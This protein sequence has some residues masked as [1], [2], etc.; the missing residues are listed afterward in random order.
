MTTARHVG[1]IDIGK[2]NAKV[3]VVDIEKEREIGVLARPNRVL[4]GPPYPHYDT[5][6]LWQFI[7]ASL[8]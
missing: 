5:E 4:S 8:R 6:E 3:A 7:C 2:T 1:V